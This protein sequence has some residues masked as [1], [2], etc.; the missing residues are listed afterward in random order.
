MQAPDTSATWRLGIAAASALIRSRELSVAELVASTI[1]RAEETEPR[2][3]AFVGVD[4]DGARRR[5]HELDGDLRRGTWH[6][7]LHGIPIAIKDVIDVAGQPTRR[8][9]RA[10]EDARP[11][12]RDAAAVRRLREAGAVILGKTT[13]H[14]LAAGSY[15]PPTR[16]PWDPER[17]PGGSS[18]GSAAAVAAGSALGAVGT[19]TLGSVRMP[20]AL[21]GIVGVKPTYG[22][23]DRA[24]VR[25]GTWSLDHVGALARTVA[26]AGLLL[27]AMTMAAA[28][29]SAEGATSAGVRIGVVRELFV[30]DAVPGVVEATERAARVLEERG[31]TLVEL[32]L[33]GASDALEIGFVIAGCEL[34]SYYETTLRERGHLI[35]ESVRALLHA[36]AV[37]TAMEY[38]RAQR[39]RSALAASVR[40]A[41]ERERIDALITPT[42]P[43]VAVRPDEVFIRCGGDDMLVHTLL[44]R[45]L[46][47]FD[48]TG[49]PAVTIPAGLAPAGL[50]VGVQLAGRP[51]DDRRL[52]GIASTLESALSPAGP[53]WPDDPRSL[54]SAPSATS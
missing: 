47:L 28:D 45:N 24:G 52:L 51:F 50:P 23:I 14:E 21:C 26:D 6:G 4:A 22:L 31:A 9:C 7:P 12:A 32:E 20:A 46:A 17:S 11:A 19:D 27:D 40:A 39:L 2:V 53:V 37:R 49:Q 44:V 1:T 10:F 13:T 34:S 36:G 48:L 8:G 25:T 16:N 43:I 54:I 41:F 5:A 18:G 33:P 38:L 42:L 15:T 30:Q 35:G 29:R 3:R